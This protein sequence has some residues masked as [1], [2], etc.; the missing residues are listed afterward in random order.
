MIVTE[1]LA[2]LFILMVP[3]ALV[4]NLVR[5]GLVRLTQRWREVCPYRWTEFSW[6]GRDFS[7]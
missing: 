3:E 6:Q 7:R 5:V 1:Q 2:K 4:L